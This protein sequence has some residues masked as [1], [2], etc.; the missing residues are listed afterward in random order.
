MLSPDYSEERFK[1]DVKEAIDKYTKEALFIFNHWL[2][3][4]PDNEL[5]NQRLAEEIE[6]RADR[7]TGE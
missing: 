7:G 1:Q 3:G 4:D 6:R 5:F 2:F